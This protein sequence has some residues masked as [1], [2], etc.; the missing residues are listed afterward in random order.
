MFCNIE[1]RFCRTLNNGYKL[2]G[3][4]SLSTA[5]LDDAYN[6]AII[7][8]KRELEEAEC[9]ALTTD[10]WSS[11]NRISYMSLTAHFIGRQ[12]KLKAR[13]L[14]IEHISGSHYGE[15]IQNSIKELLRSWNIAN[16]IQSIT[17]DNGSLNSYTYFI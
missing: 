8:I 5:L 13:T 3:Y 14:A 1:L 10:A 4:A 7:T 2:P 17:S 9:C 11:F 12:F 6:R 16:K 15:K